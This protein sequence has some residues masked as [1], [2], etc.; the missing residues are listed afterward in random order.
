MGKGGRG[1]N[2]DGFGRYCIKEEG[3][4][5]QL[6]S[7]MSLVGLFDAYAAY[8]VF[9]MIVS[10]FCI[11]FEQADDDAETVGLI[12]LYLQRERRLRMEAQRG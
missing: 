1:G 12:A 9:M 4:D 7:E 6:E 10:L 8:T 3:V 5:G 11:G 2:G